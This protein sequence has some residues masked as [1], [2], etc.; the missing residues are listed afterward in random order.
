MHIPECLMRLGKWREAYQFMKKKKELLELSSSKVL[1]WSFALCD[2]VLERRTPNHYSGEDIIKYA[3][4]YHNDQLAHIKLAKARISKTLTFT[5]NKDL[6]TSVKKNGF[7]KSLTGKFVATV[8]DG[9]GIFRLCRVDRVQQE[10][11]V[12]GILFNAYT[13]VV[14]DTLCGAFDSA[15]HCENFLKNYFR[16]TTAPRP[17]KTKYPDQPYTSLSFIPDSIALDIFGACIAETKKIRMLNHEESSILED[18]KKQFNRPNLGSPMSNTTCLQDVLQK[19]LSDL[20]SNNNTENTYN[21]KFYREMLCTP[22]F[23]NFYFAVGDQLEFGFMPPFETVHTEISNIHDMVPIPKNGVMDWIACMCEVIDHVD[24]AKK[25]LTNIFTYSA[26]YLKL[27]GAHSIA[28]DM[29]SKIQQWRQNKLKAIDLPFVRAFVERTYYYNG[30][31]ML[32]DGMVVALFKKYGLEHAISTILENSRSRLPA[33]LVP[34]NE[35]FTELSSMLARWLVR[36]KSKGKKPP[37]IQTYFTKV[38][39]KINAHPEMGEPAGTLLVSMSQMKLL[40]FVS[41]VWDQ[42]SAKSLTKAEPTNFEE[43]DKLRMEHLQKEKEQYLKTVEKEKKDITTTEAK[44]TPSDTSSS[45]QE[46]ATSTPET[47]PLPSTLSANAPPQPQKQ[48]SN[49][50]CC[51]A[52]GKPNATKRCGGC[53]SVVYCSKECQVSHWKTHKVDCKKASSK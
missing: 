31:E 44:T 21:F 33:R 47:T 20:S 25:F 15:N 24:E 2:F 18:W 40:T 49:V 12:T 27:Y 37:S 4:T 36:R 1:L 42:I 43:M 29:Y 3:E 52:C 6:F 9:Y 41:S 8:C 35:V 19:Y 16:G 50:K 23:H 38:I 30:Q 10:F 14:R 34:R 7:V 45:Q 22:F 53:H 28:N 11:K 32:L 48:A 51:A 17:Y 5:A 13:Q 46:Q 39:P 26:Y